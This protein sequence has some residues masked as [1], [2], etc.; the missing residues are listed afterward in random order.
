MHTNNFFS[1]FLN[2]L[3]N[4]FI[5]AGAYTPMSQSGFPY[6]FRSILIEL[7]ISNF[8]LKWVGHL[9]VLFSSFWF[10][11][12]VE[13]LLGQL[14]LCSQLRSMLSRQECSYRW[15]NTCLCHN[16]SSYISARVNSC[17]SFIHYDWLFN[18]KIPA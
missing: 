12:F 1:E 6:T 2:I 16:L 9:K 13:A 15:C 11:F 14:L 17:Y 18:F 5:P 4:D 8:S 10:S 3:K 7:H